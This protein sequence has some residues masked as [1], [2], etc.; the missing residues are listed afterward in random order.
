[1]PA[2]GKTYEIHGLY[3]TL[4]Y[5]MYHAIKAR[6]YTTSHHAYH[7][8]GGRGITLYWTDVVEFARY[9]EEHLG[10]RPD[11]MS[12]DR[13]NNDGNY[14]PGNIRWAPKEVQ[15]RN[16]RYRIGESGYKWVM[17]KTMRNGS[18]RWKGTFTYNGEIYHTPHS[19]TSTYE[20]FCQVIALRLET[21]NW[22]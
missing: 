15:S 22:L 4:I 1:M 18:I 21:I 3:G 17:K 11:G 8:Y 10:P 9:V 20:A 7:Y 13:I 16:R 6:C 12:L 5:R 14:E 19:Y 2:G